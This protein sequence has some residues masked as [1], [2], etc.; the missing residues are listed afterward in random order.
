VKKYIPLLDWLPRYD[1]RLLSRDAVAGITVWALAVPESMAYAG[2]A[3]VPVQ[4]GL[5]A[6]PLALLG[7]VVFGSCRQLFV[8]PSAT[9]A[10]ISAVV[11]GGVAAGSTDASRLVPLSAA[12]A[13]TVGVLYVALGL[14]RMGFVARFFAKPVL[15]G[16]IVGLGL[17]IAVG[18]FPK[19]VGVHKPDGNTVQIFFRTLRELASWNGATVTVGALALAAL[20]ALA[21]FA[22]RL[23]GALIV[24][25][26]AILS[27]DL[28]GLE[29][30]GVEIVGNVPTGF[31]FV[32]WSAVG[33][34]DI[35]QMLPGAFAI[36]I[37]GF[38]QSVAIAKSYAA[39]SGYRVDANQELIG[40]GAANLGAGAL[41]GFTVTGSLSKSA[42]AEEA[43]GKSPLLLLVTAAA[44]V[45]TILWLA[46]LFEKLPEAALAAIVI[47]AVWGMI[48]VRKL[49]RLLRTH[50]D[51]FL[52]AAGAL[53]G[54]I[55]IGILAGVVIGVA[56]S[57]V[58]LIHWLDHPRVA[59]LGRSRRGTGFA[60][61]TPDGDAV[62]VPG[63]LVYRFEASIVFANAELFGDLV[64]EAVNAAEPAPRAVV[65]DFEA[66]PDLDS[67]GEAALADLKRT[68]EG[69]GMQVAIARPLGDTRESLMSDGIGAG[70]LYSTVEDAVAA[71]ARPARNGRRPARLGSRSP[72]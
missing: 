46:G 63:V 13:L 57:F 58:L 35:E 60:E 53:L 20:F 25:A 21:R 41:Q 30:H 49:T 16:F 34:S 15:A 40:Y 31:Q 61:I 22:P 18:Q 68:L 69:R 72:E 2:I 44:T 70:R 50:R 64:L 47:H 62:P 59:V 5:Y 26:A 56:L 7:Y 51:E 4:Y 33:W 39:K 54:V 8:G 23:P 17:Y 11:V 36:V 55:L 37:V 6:I 42:A 43:R 28:F 9:V 71:L 12:L 48:D 1:R 29:A 52:L 24:A 45:L 38:A 67:T 3:G 65:L 66:V 10:S 32:S 27:V 19:L 14:L